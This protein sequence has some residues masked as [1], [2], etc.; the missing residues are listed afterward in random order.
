[1]IIIKHNG[2]HSSFVR[3]EPHTTHEHD[4]HAVKPLPFFNRYTRPKCKCGRKKPTDPRSVSKKGVGNHL[5]HTL[6]AQRKI[7]IGCCVRCMQH[8]HP[9]CAQYTPKKT[10]L[11]GVY[12]V[13]KSVLAFDGV[14]L[15]CINAVRSQ[16]PSVQNAIVGWTHSQ[17]KS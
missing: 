11:A 2:L 5:W 3:N 1:M 13:K 10:A 8:S 7:D 4:M 14:G 15:L 16:N 12:P 9:L 17:E 6:F